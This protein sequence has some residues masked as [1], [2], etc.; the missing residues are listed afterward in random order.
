[1]MYPSEETN[2]KKK[3]SS[4]ANL[5]SSYRKA[6]PYI[7]SVYTLFAALVVV[8]L[9]GWYVDKLL[10]TKP[11]FTILGLIFGMGIGF[12]GFFKGLAELNKKE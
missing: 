12:Y 4:V 10:L 5:S 2:K 3:E 6:A 8:G 1:M 9:F 11:I 7:N